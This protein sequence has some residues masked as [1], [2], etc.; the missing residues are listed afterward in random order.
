MV[1]RSSLE[2]GPCPGARI[3][4]SL[5]D[6]GFLVFEAPGLSSRELAALDAIPDAALLI[7]F[8]LMNVVV[9]FARGRRVDGEDGDGGE[10]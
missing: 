6:A 8:A 9:I 3:P 7:D 5:V 2:C 1:F 4:F 10:D